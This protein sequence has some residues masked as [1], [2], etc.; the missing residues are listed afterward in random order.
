MDPA[1]ES[2]LRL[3]DQKLRQEVPKLYDEVYLGNLY[4]Y[5]TDPSQ[6]TY[7]L[8]LTSEE[9]LKA[10]AIFNNSF[11]IP[12]QPLEALPEKKHNCDEEEEFSP[13]DMYED[14]NKATE[15]FEETQ[16]FQK[17]PFSLNGI[18]TCPKHCIQVVE[19]YLDDIY[20]IKVRKGNLK[21]PENINQDLIPFYEALNFFRFSNDAHGFLRPMYVY[22]VDKKFKSI[23]STPFYIH[24]GRYFRYFEEEIKANYVS[25]INQDRDYKCKWCYPS[26]FSLFALAKSRGYDYYDPNLIPSYVWHKFQNHPWIQG[27]AY[28]FGME[29]MEYHFQKIRPKKMNEEYEKIMEEIYE[30]VQD[31]DDHKE[32]QEKLLQKQ[33]AILNSYQTHVVQKNKK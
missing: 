33:R 11:L 25:Y 32:F 28:D 29:A 14:I 17:N 26:Y 19:D 27:E 3:L 4:Q 31:K 23:I 6:I 13:E 2:Y 8:E 5:K 21:I 22:K 12:R 9:I 10:S 16:I 18:K 1:R 7:D 20:L 15:L 24:D 30:T